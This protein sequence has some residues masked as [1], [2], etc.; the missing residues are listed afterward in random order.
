VGL[1]WDLIQHNQIRDQAN[2]SSNLE[3]RVTMLEDQLIQTRRLLQTT[4]ERLEKHVG[5]DLND[6]GRVG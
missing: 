3:Q 6:D 1:F 4:L 2:R 5:A